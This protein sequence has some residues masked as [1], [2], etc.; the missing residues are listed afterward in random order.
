MGRLLF[1]V[2]LS[3]LIN[4]GWAQ[5]Q[6]FITWGEDLKLESHQ[7]MGE[8]IGADGENT[9]ISQIDPK[10]NNG[11]PFIEKYDSA[12]RLKDR[13]ELSKPNTSDPFVFEKL[14]FMD[15]RI[16]LF[17]SQL[18]PKGKVSLYGVEIDK[19][20][21]GGKGDFRKVAEVN[22]ESKSWLPLVKK[23]KKEE[24]SS[25][26][27][28]LSE[29]KNS[30]LITTPKNNAWQHRS[31][32]KAWYFDANL[33]NEWEKDIPFLAGMEVQKLSALAL[34]ETGNA[35]FLLQ[36]STTSLSGATHLTLCSVSPKHEGVNFLPLH[37][38]DIY[39][40]QFKMVFPNPFSLSI[41]GMFS[42]KEAEENKVGISILQ[43]CLLQK[44][45]KSITLDYF[46]STFKLSSNTIDEAAALPASCL[47]IPEQVAL[48]QVFVEEDGSMLVVGEKFSS[49]QQLEPELI[50][51]MGKKRGNYVPTFYYG[52][53]LV[54]SY[55][56]NGKQKWTREIAKK[57]VSEVDL[58]LYSSYSASILDG[59]LF[60]IFNDHRKNHEEED[61][62]T[63]NALMNKEEQ[64][65]TLV[66]LDQ[67]ANQ[68]RSLLYM[69]ANHFLIRPSQVNQTGACELLVFGQHGR[70]KYKW[71]K[72]D[73]SLASI[74]Q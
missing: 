1:V 2:V 14:L 29:G 33:E 9:F 47:K 57:Q 39:V 73:L 18:E 30:L 67:D 5:N 36:H 16:Y 74:W 54:A 23:R 44:E 34:D 3:S 11:W 71:A 69:D 31:S 68:K 60:L 24:L 51:A 4:V 13:K 27:F 28:H 25:F 64:A 19:Q 59:E 46:P 53:I 49:P 50:K 70:R 72:L 21:L 6:A 42:H 8:I 10:R 35:Y 26:D 15:Q 22:S 45:L 17:V 43:V 48:N 32:L 65:V 12:L 40:D 52:D 37:I 41:M 7:S 38:E 61:G 20:S 63:F 55:T 62:H 66:Q 56:P 58:G